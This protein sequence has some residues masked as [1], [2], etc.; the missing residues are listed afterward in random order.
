MVVDFKKLDLKE[1]PLLVLRNLD[2]TPIGTLGWAFNLKTQLLYNEVSVLNF[3]YPAW[4][5]G[6][7]VPYYSDL[8]GMR[9]VELGGCG[10]FLL[11]NPKCVNSGVKEIKSCKAYSLEYELTFKKLSLE[12]GTYNFWNPAAPD[13]T[14]LGMILQR[15]PSW[16][17]SS[18]VEAV[19]PSL[20]GKYRTFDANDVN[21]YNFI[22]STVQKAY[23]CIFEFN[24]MDR[25]ISVRDTSAFVPTSSVYLSGDNLIQEIDVEEDTENIFTCLDVN[26][27]DGVTIRSVNPLGTNKLYNYDYFMQSGHFSP[28]L[29][30]EWNAWK[31]AFENKQLPYFNLKVEESNRKSAKLTLEARRTGL[32]GEKKTI[33]QEQ[34]AT[35]Q[36]LAQNPG[37]AVATKRL[38]E[39][40]R[41]LTENTQAVTQVDTEIDAIEAELK[42]LAAT[43]EQIN[44]S[45]A[46]PDALAKS[47]EFYTKED[48]IQ[49]SSFVYSEIKNYD[50]ADVSRQLTDAPFSLTDAVVTRIAN[51]HEKE[52]YAI[53]GGQLSCAGAY[54][55]ADGQPKN[56]SLEG[57]TVRASFERKDDGAFV[58]TAYLG[59]GSLGSSENSAFPG[60]NLSVTGQCAAPDTDVTPDPD[61]PGAYENGTALSFTADSARV[62]FTRNATEYEQRS[63]QWDLYEYGRDCLKKLAVPHYTFS[64]S[65]ANFLALED[66]AAFKNR[67]V[68]GR[69]VYLQLGEGRVL[70]PIA[71]CVEL[72][73]TSLSGF[74]IQFGD[75]FSYSD[76]SF[77]LADLLDQSITMGK[78]V[79]FSKYTYSSFV[80]SG[81][82]TQVKA[83]MD[84][85]LDVS[86]NAVLSATGQA[87]SWDENGIR[88]RKWNKGRTDY[89]PGQIWMINNSLVFTDDNWQSAKMALGQFVDA[90]LKSCWG[91]CA[92]NIVGTL[93]A[94]K[95]LIIES[96]KQSGDKAVFKVDEHGAVLYNS[97]FDL[98]NGT[99]TQITLNPKV[100]LAIGAPPLYSA[101]DTIDTAKA[102]FWLDTQGNIHMKGTLEAVDG[103]FTGIVQAQDFKDAQGNSMLTGGKF[104][105]D[106]LDLGH[107]TLDGVTGDISMDGNI[108][109]GGNINLSGGKITWGSNVP[110]KKRYA[111]STSGPWHET[112]QS[113]DIYCCDWNYTINDWSP[114]YKFVAKDGQDGAPGAPGKSPKLP[115][116]IK[117][118][119]ITK[120]TIKSPKITGGLLEGGQLKVTGKILSDYS[121]ERSELRICDEEDNPYGFIRYDDTGRPS[122]TEEARYR[123]FI[124]TEVGRA[125]KIQS[126]ANMSIQANQGAGTIYIAGKVSFSEPPLGINVYFE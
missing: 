78:Q 11:F 24:S 40:N 65:A 14:L 87:Q 109:L 29:E 46:L 45:L 13:G 77:Q 114:A 101:D 27:A 49:E 116:Y 62:Y 100:G 60:G 63:V 59:S 102:K 57:Q 120:T 99:N 17:L 54:T 123:M 125:M 26:G 91:I 95:N 55:D 119:E 15:M 72:D 106:Y 67:F 111:A 7:A 52:L 70:Q 38:E 83:F 69:K 42:E 107:I 5:D 90:Q 56:F 34:A 80:D 36:Y 117:E 1:P 16:R 104:S 82:A 66:F 71:V 23:N 76:A 28:E 4:D 37:D 64:V 41:L 118:N 44:K 79:D 121:G 10:R 94:G 39:L 88:L 2:G 98:Y 115:E 53:T 47:L 20:V 9:I 92:P 61:I 18:T 6:A 84:S 86:K 113:G 112:I 126:G 48:A 75:K 68:L 31:A 110:N 73:Y 89:A 19:S 32:D 22:K 50:S 30:S 74:T 8:T 43:A 81:A 105:S 3:D 103:K 93:L 12:K 58:F 97:T 33:E 85:A 35:A 25:T 21:V 51:S 124:A 122:T 96:Q 108:T